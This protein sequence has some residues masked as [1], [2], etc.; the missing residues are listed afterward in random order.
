M[1]FNS[2]NQLKTALVF[3]TLTLLGLVLYACSPQ[4]SPTPDSA[5]MATQ[6]VQTYQAQLSSTALANPSATPQPST[7]PKPTDTPAPAAIVNTS[8]VPAN[9]KDKAELLS[10]NPSDGAEIGVDENFDA[11]WIIRNEGPTTW[12][13]NLYSLAYYGGLAMGERERYF[14]DE[15]VPPGTS[16]T[17]VVD[18]IA[19][20]YTGRFNTIWALSNAEGVNFYSV[21]L[22]VN[23][24]IATTTPSPTVTITPGTP[25]P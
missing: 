14:L 16:T 22:T 19:P 3:I 4:A 24:V 21:D 2:S 15:D 20:H 13:K 11:V 1:P 8:T 17:I 23:I 5:L 18:M 10:Q 9:V 25:I 12:Q 6:A 7:T